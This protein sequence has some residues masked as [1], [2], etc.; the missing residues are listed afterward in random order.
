MCQHSTFTNRKSIHDITAVKMVQATSNTYTCSN[1]RTYTLILIVI[2]RRYKCIIF[3]QI[4]FVGG[5]KNENE[6]RHN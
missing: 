4:C 1:V 2:Y 5:W 3:T 6:E